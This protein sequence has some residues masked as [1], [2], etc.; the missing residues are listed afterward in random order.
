MTKPRPL[1]INRRP[2]YVERGGFK[3]KY[4]DKNPTGDK[5]WSLY[6]VVTMDY[7][8]EIEVVGNIHENPELLK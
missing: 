4:K 6:A 8:D 5:R 3:E 2:D 7:K 1:R